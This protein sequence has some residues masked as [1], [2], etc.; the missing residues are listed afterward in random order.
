MVKTHALASKAI[1]A[2]RSLVWARWATSRLLMKNEL[3]GVLRS[4]YLT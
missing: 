2:G 4:D 3:T 1:G